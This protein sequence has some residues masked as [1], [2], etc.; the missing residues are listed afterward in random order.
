MS[1]Y[2]GLSEAEIQEALSRAI[3]NRNKKQQPKPEV[4][5]VAS[6]YDVINDVKVS[7][8]AQ[9][10]LWDDKDTAGIITYDVKQLSA[11]DISSYGHGFVTRLGTGQLT[12]SDVDICLAM[13]VSLPKP[14]ISEF[15]PLLTPPEAQYGKK[16]PFLLPEASNVNVN[17]QQRE[18][19]IRLYQNR[20]DKAAN[21]EEKQKAM[22]KMAELEQR[23]ETNSP[24]QDAGEIS[25]A[26]ASAYAYMA[27]Y[28]MRLCGKLATSFSNSWEKSK[29]RYKAWYGNTNTKFGNFVMT[30][31]IATAFKE[32]LQRRP[33]VESTWVM[34]VAYNENENKSLARNDLG[35]LT[36]LACQMF[37]YKGMHCYSLFLQIHI[38][39]GIQFGTMLRELDCPATRLACE[40]LLTMVKDYEQTAKFPKRKTYFRYARVWDS[41]YFTAL[42]TKNCKMLTYVLASTTKMISSQT[43][44]SDPVS[45]QGIQG[46]Q[47]ELRV[48]LDQVA[49]KLYAIVYVDST[50][51]STSGSIWKGIRLPQA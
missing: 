51:D 14:G 20:I 18:I 7:L 43:A 24:V 8:S 6:K 27:A 45:I 48:T 33:E 40:A 16:I 4:T 28:L 50:Q 21:E 5:Q 3:L 13:A 44:S 12:S 49:K 30:E 37:S 41:G 47:D 10:K 9:A 2:A 32:H 42:Q 22:E 1:Q 35:L 19:Q 38:A 31:A 17:E 25:T 15:T 29:E 26:E 34:W 39:T 11:R 46:I 36:Y 23:K